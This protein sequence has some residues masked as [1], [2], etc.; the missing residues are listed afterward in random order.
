MR[1]EYILVFELPDDHELQGR[2]NAIG[3]DIEDIMNEKFPR[4]YMDVFW[5]VDK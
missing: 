4:I 2:T 3:S 5:K 1:K